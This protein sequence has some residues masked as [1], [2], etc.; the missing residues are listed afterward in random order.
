[1]HRR[2]RPT[3]NYS[4]EAIFHDVRRRLQGR[5]AAK[6]WTA[7]CFS[8]G[9]FRRLWIT[10][11]AALNQSSVNHVTGDINFA[12]VLLRRSRTVLTILDCGDVE[13]QT[14]LRGWA[15]RTI[16]YWLP[17]RR[18]ARITTISHAVKCD[19]VRLTGCL[20]EKIDVIPVAISN[21]FRRSER[22]P[23]FECPRILQVGTSI[24]KNLSRLMAALSGLPCTLVI[25]GKLNEQTLLELDESGVAFENHVNIS[26]QAL[27]AE[28]DKSDIVAFASTY[29]G[30]GMPIVEA[31]TVGRPVL[32][33][34]ISSMPEVAGTGACLV[35]PF[36]VDS[37]RAGFQRIISDTEY[38]T[39]LI[40]QGFENARRFDAECIANQYLRVYQSVAAGEQL[41]RA[42]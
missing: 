20:E 17:V 6:N 29:E 31:Q 36:D 41:N 23:G 28:Y 42:A 32:T 5:I 1:M 13:S 25:V 22:T 30:F 12:S 40:Q 18:S 9:L 26:E 37:I 15:L 39:K 27:I 19:I 4:L 3:G 38:R 21:A 35:D 24:N 8:N 11:S 34:N 2:P 10:C 16:W 14:G 7:P 33:S